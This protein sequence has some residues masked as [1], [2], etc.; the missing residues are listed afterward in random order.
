VN[1]LRLRAYSYAADRSVLRFAAGD[2]A[3]AFLRPP[4]R[5]DLLLLSIALARHFSLMFSGL[6]G[7][8]ISTAPSPSSCRC[9][10][11]RCWRLFFGGSWVGG[12]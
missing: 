6:V 4:P 5:D 12:G 3:A 8:D 2:R 9:R 1:F 7:L 11:R 10:P